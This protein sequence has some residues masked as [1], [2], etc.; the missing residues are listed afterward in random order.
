MGHGANLPWARPAPEHGHLG[1]RRHLLGCV[2]PGA[3]QPQCPHLPSTAPGRAWAPTRR[4][5]VATGG[6]PGLV[7]AAMHHCP[8]LRISPGGQGRRRPQGGGGTGSPPLPAAGRGRG[9]HGVPHPHRPPPPLWA[10][11]LRPDEKQLGGG[12]E[13]QVRGPDRGGRAGPQRLC[14]RTDGLMATGGSHGQGLGLGR[15]QERLYQRGMDLDP[16][17]AATGSATPARLRIPRRVQWGRTLGLSLPGLG[18]SPSPV[19]PECASPE[20]HTGKERDTQRLGWGGEGCNPEGPQ[21]SASLCLRSYRRPPL[22]Q[23]PLAEPPLPSGPAP[24]PPPPGSSPGAL[25]SWE[26]GWSAQCLW[27]GDNRRGAM[28]PATHSTER[29]VPQRPF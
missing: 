24:L 21:D 11:L 26:S 5:Q 29:R 9:S 17:H 4:D 28:L 3:H 22:P 27:P 25:M 18:G 13:P 1:S 15:W 14:P 2:G 16:Q 19:R 8:H 6:G 10:Q 12:Q 7:P 20:R 23:T